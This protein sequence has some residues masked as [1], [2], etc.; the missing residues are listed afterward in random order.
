MSWNNNSK[1]RSIILAAILSALSF[2]LMRFVEFPIFASFPFLK[3]D[4]GDVPL[5]I[6]G[7]F[8]GPM[9]ALAIAFVKNLLF[10]ISGA[11]QGGPLG[12]LVNFIA[13]GTLSVVAGL[14]SYR[15]QKLFWVI[16]G[17]VL[18]TIVF[19]LVMIPTNLWAVPLFMPGITRQALYEY[20]F[21]VNVPFNLIKGMID[22]ALIIPLWL[23]LRKRNLFN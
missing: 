15:R 14:I 4:L 10:L 19:T 11:G 3:T 1:L 13:V 12:V 8:L 6:G 23:T 16:F 7:I 9:Y 2:I 5:L 17:V 22:L 18:G 20:I 21:K